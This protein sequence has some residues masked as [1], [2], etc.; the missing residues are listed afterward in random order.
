[1]KSIEHLVLSGGSIKG[2]GFIGAFKYLTEC[3]FLTNVKSISGTSIGALF[4]V[5]IVLGFTPKEMENLSN[6][7]N[8]TELVGSVCLI[9]IFDVYSLFL[10]DKLRLFLKACFMYKNTNERITFLE[11][12]NKT[13]VK[14]NLITTDVFSSQEFIIN[15]VTCPNLSVING[16]LM[17]VNIPILWDKIH[18]KGSY[19]IDGCFSNN[20]PLNLVENK[21]NT[22]GIYLKSDSGL[23][24]ECTFLNYLNK[25]LHIPLSCK[26]TNDINNY[27]NKGCKIIELKLKT[28]SSL[29]FSF[30]IH[31]TNRKKLINEGYNQTKSYFT[32]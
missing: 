19:Y 24:I 13:G 21:K 28:S 12:Y 16:I 2:I 27:K 30:L 5:F 9:D 3:K 14:I 7:I 8:Y 1:M 15:H 22:L 4:S 11:L 20:F 6:V 26:N 32:N 31:K 23:K 29:D 17:S 25:I 10:K 18:Y